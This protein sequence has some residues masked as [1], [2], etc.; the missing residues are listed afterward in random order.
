MHGMCEQTHLELHTCD[1]ITQLVFTWK[2]YKRAVVPVVIICSK[3][4]KLYMQH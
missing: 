4:N 3:S 2:S 1:Y